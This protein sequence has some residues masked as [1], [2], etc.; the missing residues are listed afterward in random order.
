MSISV[1]HAAPAVETAEVETRRRT[2]PHGVRLAI[3]QALLIAAALYL[4]IGGWQRDL[5]VP[6]GFSSDSLWFLMQGKSTLDNGWWWSNPRLGAPFAFDALAYPS[7]SNVDQSLV[8]IVGRFLSQPIAV[9]NLAWGLTVILSGLAATWCLRRLGVSAA[10][11]LAAGTLYALSPYALYR[12]IDHFS[13]VI[14]LV[15]FACAAALWLE[16]GRPMRVWPRRAPLVV[17]AGCALLGFN[18]VYYAFFGAFCVL[19]G[20]LIGFVAHRDRRILASGALCVGVITACTLVNL[21]PSFSSWNMHGRPMMMRDKV[22]AEAEM[23]GLKIRQLVSPVFPHQFP[24]FRAWVEQEAAAKFPNESENWT[25]RLG[26]TGTLG[27]LGLLTLLFVPDTTMSRTVAARMPPSRTAAAHAT[28]SRASLL[29]RGASRLTLAALLLATVGGFGSLFSLFI[30]ADIRA[31]NRICPFIEFFSLLAIALAIDVVFKTRRV[32]MVAAT[33]VLAVGLADQGQ[34]AQHFQVKYASIASEVAGLESFVRTVERAV[35]DSAMVLQLPFRTY[36]NES[37]FGRMKR[38]D[39]LKPYL[40]SRSLRFSYPALSDAQVRWQQATARLDP[41]TLISRIA[42]EGFAV[43]LID[44]YGYEDNGTAMAD[45][46]VRVTGEQRV[47]A[48]TERYL[49]LDIRGLAVADAAAVGAELVPATLS[50]T[51]CKGQPMMVLD[52]IGTA[53]SPFGD[54]SVRVSSSDELRVSG[55]AVD[56]PSKSAANAVDV[57]IDRTPFASTYG[58]T[59]DDVAEYFQRP[60]YRDTGFTASIPGSAIAKGEHTL[61]LRVV[62]ADGRCYFQSRAIPVT[63]E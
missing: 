48:R 5:A 16:S 17:L 20:A 54:G 24:P 21:T 3:A 60:G 9:V 59:R 10:S 35:P 30:S 32:R 52:Q 40:V 14:Y 41:R 61:T 42:S 13:L 51:A 47:I 49:A 25:A 27:F 1:I 31:Y 53:R 4:F 28:L 11:A 7:N 23:F 56:H 50:M 6:F 45:A 39:H 2:M 19:A 57:V 62:A 38:Y 34:A 15:P 26:F 29:S 36:L 58:A 46:L 18:Y 37:D 8:W 55:W 44:R 63:V 12:H 33:A 22:P 43:I